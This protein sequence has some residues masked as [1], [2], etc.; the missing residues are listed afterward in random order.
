LLKKKSRY[1]VAIVGAAGTVGRELVEIL[2]ERDFPAADVVLLDSAESEGERIEVRGRNVA[3]RRLGKDAFPDADIAFFFAGAANS[4]E[5]V[6]AAAAA[7]SVVIDGSGA[8]RMDPTTPLVVAEVNLQS[9]G[10]HAGIIATPD[11]SVIALVMALKP[12]HDAA[13]IKRV[14]ITTF[15]SVSGTGKEAIDELAG[16]TVALLNFRDFVNKAYPHQIA[17]NCIPHVDAFMES[18]GTTA[19]VN[20]RREARKVLADDTLQLTATAVRVPVFRS[21]AASLN[22]EMTDPLP[23]NEA[24]FLLSRASGVVVYDD[25]VRDLYPLQIDVS[26]KDDVYVGR[27]RT[28]DSVANGLNLWLAWDNIRK[29]A[30]LNAVQIAEYLVKQ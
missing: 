12:L 21:D 27:I 20:M 19:E 8:F 29:G 23:P 26:G 15:Q 6:P 22:I 11:S 14:V 28:D 4:R 2:E 7:G 3:V 10:S 13:R 18:G 24:R 25:P 17:F 16:Q 9:I 30:A 1:I 5:H